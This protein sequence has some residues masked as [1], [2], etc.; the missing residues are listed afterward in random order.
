MA[1][2]DIWTGCEVFFFSGRGGGFFLVICMDLASDYM[3]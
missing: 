2:S 3:A 1:V